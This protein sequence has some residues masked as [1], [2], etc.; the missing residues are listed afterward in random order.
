MGLHQNRKIKNSVQQSRCQKYALR[1]SAGKMM[2]AT[3]KAAKADKSHPA[4]MD[5]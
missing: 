5:Q 4:I 3:K 2:T 1:D